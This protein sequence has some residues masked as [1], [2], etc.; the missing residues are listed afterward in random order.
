VNQSPWAISVPKIDNRSRP[1]ND[2]F[3][4]L[5]ES[6]ALRWQCGD[7]ELADAVDW[8]QAIAEQNGLIKQI[9]QDAV[10]LIMARAFA[11]VRDDLGGWRP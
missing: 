3:R 2:V 5:C 10:Q 8:L 7:L 9:G 11:A 1:I 6:R 4:A